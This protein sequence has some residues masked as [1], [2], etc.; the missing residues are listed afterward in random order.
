[1]NET[2]DDKP[3]VTIHM[4]ASL[5]GFIA[6]RDGSVDWLETP[7]T[8]EG[9]STMTSETVEAFLRTIDCYVMGS[10]TY[11]TALGFEA[12]GFGWSY[13]DKPTFVLT[14]RTL[15]KTRNT[16]EFYAGDLARLVDER[17]KPTFRS[18]WF[19]GGGEL[20][21]ECL[22]L[23][24]ADEVRYSIVPVLIGDGIAFFEGLDQ[25]VALHLLESTAY[26][27]GMVALRYEVRHVDS[28][29]A[30][31]QPDPAQGGTTLTPK[32]TICLW[33]DK[34]AQDAARFYAATFP[35]S[36]V[37]AVRKAPG[38]Y[39]DGKAGDV[40]TVEFTVC[41]IPCLG[42]NGGPAF[43]HNEA[44]SF[45]IATDTQ[46]ETDRYWNAIVGNGGEESQCG[47]CRDRWGLSWQI[48]PRTLTDAMAAGGAEA[49]RAFEAMMPMKKIDVAAIDAA[50][51]G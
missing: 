38:D 32:N 28:I 3:R 39:P 48:T 50:R 5:D 43:K 49:K 12:K 11:E 22:R 51:R 23:G 42:L 19:V 33:Y 26:K 16:V 8:F 6:R 37:T 13:G 1:M 31:V 44:F 2:T 24:L 46:E 35:D 41:G 20:S 14:R 21:A 45:Q 10:R 29:E 18:I 4:V 7:D 30:G 9:G 34:D 15:P 40:L 47:W 27:N 36:K 17:L 25:D